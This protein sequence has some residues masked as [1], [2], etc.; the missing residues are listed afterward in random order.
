MHEE[1]P[2]VFC[3]GRS[4]PGR[5]G[6][7]ENTRVRFYLRGGEEVQGVWRGRDADFILIELTGGRMRA[8]NASTVEM[9]EPVED[10]ASPEAIA[11][12]IEGA[13]R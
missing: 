1:L 2:F 6:F 3:E 7:M 13:E 5:W 12:E 11:R 9:M 10:E 8:Y 4:G